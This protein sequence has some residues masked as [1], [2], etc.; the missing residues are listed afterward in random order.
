MKW[1]VCFID[2]GAARSG[3]HFESSRFYKVVYLSREYTRRASVL[4]SNKNTEINYI[5]YPTR[6]KWNLFY[7]QVTWFILEFTTQSKNLY[8]K[9][10]LSIVRL[11]YQSNH[12]T[13]GF[14]FK[15]KKRMS[16]ETADK[17]QANN[18]RQPRDLR[19]RL[20]RD[21]LG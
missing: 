19:P 18:V 6:R 12:T 21:I 11:V 15:S 1:G 2:I 7:G 16:T 20:G 10:R 13:Q 8:Q 9:R 14:H 5:K 4:R 17:L 3:S